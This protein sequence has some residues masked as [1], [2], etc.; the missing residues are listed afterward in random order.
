VKILRVTPA[1][2]LLA[3]ALPFVTT[4]KPPGEHDLAAKI[5]GIW[6]AHPNEYGQLLRGALQVFRADKTFADTGAVGSGSRN[7]ELQIEGRWWLE[8]NV[9]CEEVTKSNLP[10]IVPVGR[11]YRETILGISEEEMWARDEDGTEHL[12]TRF[13]K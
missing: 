2:A 9:L 13:K 4:A 6:M 8:G 12:L 1:F 7:L 11:R 10:E 5:I 3:V